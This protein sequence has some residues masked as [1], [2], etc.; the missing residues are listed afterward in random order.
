MLQEKT[1]QILQKHS[2][3][4]SKLA[5]P[6][7]IVQKLYRNGVFSKETFDEV[8]KAKGSLSGSP[9]R[10]LSNTVSKQFNQLQIFANF[11]LQSED[12]VDV[13][14]DILKEYGMWPWFYILYFIITIIIYSCIYRSN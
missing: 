9:L 12:T 6:S 13:A 7:E 4:L 11:L 8:E 10:A 5:L 14:N 1:G 2:E 3:S